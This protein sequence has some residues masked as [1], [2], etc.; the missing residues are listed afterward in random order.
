MNF[1]LSVV[2]FTLV[3]SGFVYR[4]CKRNKKWWKKRESVTETLLYGWPILVVIL[5]TIL[6][7]RPLS[8]VVMLLLNSISCGENVPIWWCQ[9][10][11]SNT[12]DDKQNDMLRRRRYN[13]QKFHC[14]T[15]MKKKN[16]WTCH[17]YKNAYYIWYDKQK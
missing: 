5:T 9:F 13:Q 3:S 2:P 14:G 4:M 17:T 1:V 16:S 7:S 11:T 8:F 10:P 15:L 6:S 12:F